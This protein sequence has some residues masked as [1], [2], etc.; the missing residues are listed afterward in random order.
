MFSRS[1]GASFSSLL[2]SDLC[3]PPPC[4][5]PPIPREENL[6]VQVSGRVTCLTRQSRLFIA[7]RAGAG[8]MARGVESAV[9]P[10]FSLLL[11]WEIIS[12]EGGIW[13]TG[14]NGTWGLR[15][16]R[17]T[18]DPDCDRVQEAPAGR[19]RPLRARALARTRAAAGPPAARPSLPRWPALVALSRRAALVPPHPGPSTLGPLAAARE[20]GW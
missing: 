7:G 9:S 1:Q 2:T 8:G 10:G 20:G 15:D 12:R 13:R 18:R 5:L 11:H 4:P 6:G 19:P 16:A 17:G 14:D 3:L